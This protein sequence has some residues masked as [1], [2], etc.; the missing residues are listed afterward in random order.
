MPHQIQMPAVQYNTSSLK[1][2]LQVQRATSFPASYRNQKNFSVSCRRI[3]VFTVT[4]IVDNLHC[5]KAKNAKPIET[6]GLY[7]KCVTQILTQRW[8]RQLLTKIYLEKFCEPTQGQN[9]SLGQ[10]FGQ[11]QVHVHDS[12][13]QVTHSVCNED[14][15]NNNNN[16][17]KH[18]ENNEC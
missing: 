5:C 2:D 9:S 4:L 8:N 15:L 17:K 6:Y 11:N 16:K 1:N 18:H 10:R 14:T 12:T 13:H 7:R 3:L